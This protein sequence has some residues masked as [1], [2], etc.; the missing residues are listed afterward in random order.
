MPRPASRAFPLVLLLALAAVS[1]P[2]AAAAPSA[3]PAPSV[4]VPDPDVMLGPLT[5]EQ[6]EEAY[7][8]Y[9]QA[10]AEAAI[11]SEAAREL[12][13]VPPGASLVVYFGTWCSDSR[14][15]LGRFWRALDEI[16][17]EKGFKVEYV[18]VDRAKAEPAPLLDGVDLHHVPTFVVRREAVEVGRVVEKSPHGIERDLADLLCGRQHGY[19]SATQAPP[20]AAAPQPSASPAPPAQGPTGG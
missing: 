13:S 4:G 16:A 3:S 12:V 15:E 9:V 17:D 1:A 5:R 19:L 10:E 14:R 11:D 8:L 7:P 18:G 20:G 2:G 6:V